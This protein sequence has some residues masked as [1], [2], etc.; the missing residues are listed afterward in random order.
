MGTDEIRRS[1][2]TVANNARRIH[3]LAATTEQGILD[4]YEA[5]ASLEAIAAATTINGN[6]IGQYT[7]EG[8]RKVLLRHGIPM[9]RRGRPTGT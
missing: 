8:V 4:A 9:R 3:D 5:G 7:L 6:G 1:L 2:D